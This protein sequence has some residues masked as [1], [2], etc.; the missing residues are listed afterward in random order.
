MWNS[1][2]AQG[3]YAIAQAAALGLS[4]PH[5]FY[6]TRCLQIFT[7]FST[8]FGANRTTSQLRFVVSGQAVNVWVMRQAMSV[9]GLAAMANIIAIAPY[10]DCSNIGNSTNSA[11]YSIGSVDDIISRC[12]STLSTM[13]S[14]ITPY[15]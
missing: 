9:P 15:Q 8:V 6:G 14:A 12:D 3:K 11:Y 4:N 7:I 2:F 13:D 10:F 1:F 5:V